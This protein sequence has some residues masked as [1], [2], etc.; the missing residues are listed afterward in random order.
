V[1]LCVNQGT[2]SQQQTVTVRN[3]PPRA[4]FGYTTGGETVT[5]TSTSLDLDGPIVAYAWDLDDDGSF[6]DASS[7][8]ASVSLGPGFHRVGLRVLDRDGAAA[9]VYRPIVIAEPA[10]EL[11]RPF[12]LV[13]LSAL[14]TR[15]GAQV[16][17]LGVRAAAGVRVTVHCRGRS[18]PWRR[19]TVVS[20]DGSVRFR[21]LQR[22]LR[23]GTVIE[24][25][26][27]KRG[28]VGKYTRF[29]IRRGRVPA[30]VDS[31]FVAG[32]GRA[33]RCPG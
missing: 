15:G 9:A 21:R 28:F 4:W 19:R 33:S 14:I 10:L 5:L 23:A 22:K 6:D 8:A 27:G 13:R 30:R 2:S 20:K 29:R 16:E 11:L 3:R 26:A 24:V 17:L 7:I 12:P 25:F 31:C 18:C 32:T 1:A